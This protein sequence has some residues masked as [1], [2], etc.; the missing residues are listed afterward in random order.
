[1]CRGAAATTP[2]QH[3]THRAL[4]AGRGRPQSRGTSCRLC[5]YGPESTA[6]DF[7]IRCAQAA[8]G[9]R[10]A[11]AFGV[12]D[13]APSS[14]SIRQ[15]P[16]AWSYGYSRSPIAARQWPAPAAMHGCTQAGCGPASLPPHQRGSSDSIPLQ[17]RRE[18]TD[19][20]DRISVAVRSAVEKPCS[21]C[22]ISGKISEAV[23]SKLVW[24]RYGHA[25]IEHKGMFA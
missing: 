17:P 15:S 6:P 19:R 5:R 16:A 18:Q 10:G 1:M 24:F 12:R 9:S 3:A 23:R 2:H 13:G 14:V 20:R 25:P 11:P 8:G 21:A 22:S 7:A 4:A